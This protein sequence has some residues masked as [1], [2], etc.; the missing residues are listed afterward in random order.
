MG[1]GSATSPAVV[2]RGWKEAKKIQVNLIGEYENA[3]KLGGKRTD[4]GE[5]R[6]VDSTNSPAANT[7]ERRAA[8]PEMWMSSLNSLQAPPATRGSWDSYRRAPCFRGIRAQ[9]KNL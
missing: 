8:V 7:P 4:A 1:A 5:A 3:R 2:N 9:T 6:A